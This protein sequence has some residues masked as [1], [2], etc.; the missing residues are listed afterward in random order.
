MITANCGERG[1]HAFA[2]SIAALT[3]FLTALIGA[4]ALLEQVE[5]GLERVA[6]GV[7]TL[8]DAVLDRGD[9]PVERRDRLLDA[10]HDPGLEALAQRGEA[11]DQAVADREE[12]PATAFTLSATT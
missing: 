11:G 9:D 12:R 5:A 6:D 3:A 7:I 10:V 8:A 2:F 4:D 1:N